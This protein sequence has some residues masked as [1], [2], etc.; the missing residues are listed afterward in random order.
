M[1]ETKMLMVLLLLLAVMGK[2]SIE[3]VFDSYVQMSSEMGWKWYTPEHKRSLLISLITGIL[4]LTML[5]TGIL[6]N[7]YSIAP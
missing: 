2:S 1:S 7:L 3:V 5:L 6:I 4:T